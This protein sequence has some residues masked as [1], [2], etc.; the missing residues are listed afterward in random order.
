MDNKE[1]GGGR[2]CSR[3]WWKSCRVRKT[4]NDCDL[5]VKDFLFVSL[6]SSFHKKNHKTQKKKQRKKSRLQIFWKLGH[7]MVLN[8]RGFRDTWETLFWQCWIFSGALSRSSARS[9]LFS[10]P[11]G[12][13]GADRA[14]TFELLE[15]IMPP[16]FVA[17]RDGGREVWILSPQARWFTDVQSPDKNEGYAPSSLWFFLNSSLL[18]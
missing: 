13:F 2:S 11:G 18:N 4:K 1:G 16:V 17:V 7:P 6:H 12:R 8:Q 3:S 9:S 14:V 10:E 15:V 5:I